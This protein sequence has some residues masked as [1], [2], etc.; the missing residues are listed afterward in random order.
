[1]RRLWVCLSRKT[2]S[3]EQRES[4]GEPHRLLEKAWIPCRLWFWLNSTVVFFSDKTWITW[5]ER[6]IW[7][8]SFI[9]ILKYI[10]KDVFWLN[11]TGLR[12]TTSLANYQPQK[13]S[14]FWHFFLEKRSNLKFWRKIN[15]DDLKG[16]YLTLCEKRDI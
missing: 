10:K 12:L 8:V 3:A 4:E 16:Q 14:C 15:G 2:A 11:M 13:S 7:K 5:T 6:I 1:M 9:L